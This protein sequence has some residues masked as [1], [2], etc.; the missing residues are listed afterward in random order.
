[1]SH[2]RLA[3]A[4]P[5]P[6]VELVEIAQ[7]LG[8]LSPDWT[9]PERF[10]ERRSDLVGRLRAL[11]RVSDGVP[12]PPRPRSLIEQAMAPL[13]PRVRVVMLPIRL[14]PVKRHRYP[15]PPADVPA[16]GRLFG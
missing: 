12:W 13:P 7:A 4:A 8:R 2:L 3:A 1:V 11:A 15:K 5:D 9:R 14:Y 10:F 16:Q 6:A